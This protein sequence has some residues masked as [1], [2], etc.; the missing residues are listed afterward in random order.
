METRGLVCVDYKI[1][2]FPRF[3]RASTEKI[4]LEIRIFEF[5][6]FIG[7]D[8]PTRFHDGNFLI[9]FI[10]WLKIMISIKI[11]I[12][13]TFSITRCTF[14]TKISLKYRYKIVISHIWIKT[15]F[16]VDKFIRHHW[17]RKYQPKDIWKVDYPWLK[18]TLSHKNNDKISIK[19]RYSPYL[20]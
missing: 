11:M 8:E 10:F 1:K 12:I 15:N 3:Y 5:I 14:K 7:F 2:K 16:S 19:H 18:W 17:K 13:N 4:D 6:G 9:S 20:P